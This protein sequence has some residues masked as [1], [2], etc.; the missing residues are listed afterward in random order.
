MCE[1]KSFRNLCEGSG[2]KVERDKRRALA[3]CCW[4]RAEGSAAAV[5]QILEAKAEDLK[6]VWQNVGCKY[7]LPPISQAVW[8]GGEIEQNYNVQKTSLICP[9]D[10][11]YPEQLYVLKSPPILGVKGSIELLKKAQ[12]AVVGSRHTVESSRYLTPVIADAL[13]M[14]GYI[15]TS[16]GAIGIDALAHRQAMA[17]EQPTI[18]VSALGTEHIYPKENADIFDYAAQCGALVSQF[19]NK[20]L[21]HKPNFPQRNDVIAGLS[22]GVVVVQCPAKS[23]ALYTVQAAR[24]FH[25]PVFVAAMPGFDPLTEGGLECV[26]KQEAVLLSSSQDLAFMTQHTPKQRQ[27]D[28]GLFQCGQVVQTTVLPDIMMSKTQLEILKLV[29]VSGM[30]RELL[31]QNMHFPEDFDEAI[32]ELELNGQIKI[33]AGIVQR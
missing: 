12:M 29:S 23:G 27:L 31:R 24:R 28:F 33:N 17:R 13:M 9:G 19:P 16:G 2:D 25:R 3:I 1:C 30:T 18:V 6:T 4:H 20:G 7:T 26:K 14:S 8:E 5:R 21:N 11:H 10:P 15:M 22:L 32:L